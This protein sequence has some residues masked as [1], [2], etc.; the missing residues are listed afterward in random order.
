[1]I[2]RFTSLKVAAAALLLVAASGTFAQPTPGQATPSTA[3]KALPFVSPIFGDNM[4]LQRDKPDAIWG[5]SDPGDTVRVQIGDKTATA[6]AGADRR[7]QVKI[8]P[9]AAGGPYTVSITGHQTVELHNVLVGDVWLCGGQSNMGLPL[10]F[11]KNADDEIKAANFPEIRFFTV[12]GHPAY[13]HMD[14]I[15]GN[16][17]AVSPETA[18]SVSAVAYY[19]ARKVQQ[20]IHVPIGLVV[21]AVGGTPAEAWAS[22]AA[23]RPL[24]DFDVPLDELDRLKAADAPEYGNYV[25]HWYDQYDIGQKEKWAV[26]DLDDSAWKRVPVPGGFA[27]LGVPDTPALVWFRREITLPDP[28]PKPA[29]EANAAPGPFPRGGVTLHLGSI[30]RMDTAYVNGVEV[31]GSAWVENPR[32]YFIRPGVLKPGRNVIAIRVLKTKPDGGFLSKP[33]DLHLNLADGSTIPLAG[34]WKAKLSVDARPPHPLPMGYE[35]WPVMPSVLYEG[36]LA[37]I[38]PMSIT[39]AI[40][41]QGEQNSPRG[42]QYRRILPAM[43]ADWRSLFCQGDFPFYIVSLPAFTKHSSVPVDGDDWTETRESQAIAAA[44][45]PNACLAVTI[46]TGDPDNIHAKDKQPVG[47]RLARCALAKHY[48]KPIVY[49]GPT[50]ESVERLPGSIRLHFAHADGGL[51]V[52]GDHLGE[53]SIAGDDR[54]WYWADARIEG[55]T[56]VVTSPSVPNPTQVRYAWQSNPVATLFN[57]AGLPAAPFRTDH[58]PGKTEAARPY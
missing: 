33:D 13:H 30:E 2:Q 36:M 27:E 18:G 39:G 52:K 47:D 49:S 45:V 58:W 46:D 20:E 57:G 6:T 41:Y 55:D 51:V 9:P 5:W 43:I 3:G 34:E 48:G 40:W 38:A 56:V 4:V 35:N 42:F 29:A 12:E 14:V 54:K 50:L 28:L 8:Q 26:P 31:G 15:E 24:H 23:L 1:M 44:S 53:F 17:R 10:R 32:M 37:P 19:F 22:E 11:T 7:W 21:D 16:W 25:M